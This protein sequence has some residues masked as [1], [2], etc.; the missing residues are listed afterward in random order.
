MRYAEFLGF[1]NLHIKI[2]RKTGL[3]AIVAIHNL[4][5]G[6]AIGGCRMVHYQTIDLAMED[7]LRLAYMMSYKAAINNLPH[8]GAKAVLIKPKV[9]KDYDAY[10]EKFGEF[11]DE[12]GGRYI[13]AIDSGTS[14]R[15]MDI[16]AR[17]TKFVTCTSQAGGE[18]DPSPFTAYGVMRAI[19]AAVKFKLKRDSLDGI[20]V[21]IQGA[22][23]VGYHLAKDLVALGAKI[24]ITDVNE[25]AI[26]RAVDTLSVTVC[27]PDEIYQI[28]ADVFAPCALG[29][30]LNLKN[31]KQLKAKIV[32]GSANNQLAHSHYGTLLHERGILYA[33]D[34]L[35][36]AGGLIHVAVV[37]DKGNR[38]RSMQQIQGIH[39][40]VYD[41]YERS[42]KENRAT[43]VI[44]EEIARERLS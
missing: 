14:T 32:A 16:I 34:F 1:G 2:D 17:K 37:Y 4:K 24:T 15:E 27:H 6:P 10:F 31:I 12:L 44:A 29:S 40:T 36:N 20:H 22:G 25:E 42:E 41:I 11:V 7:A 39:D 19:E 38:E 3:K 8:G 43:N 21:A 13:T 18:D 28:D 23:Q 30:T 5:R 9:I 35:I 26:K 33:P